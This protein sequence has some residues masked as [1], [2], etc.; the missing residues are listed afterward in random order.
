M[1]FLVP[2]KFDVTQTTPLKSANRSVGGP[3]SA[4]IGL[5]CSRYQFALHLR[6]MSS[7]ALSR[8]KGLFQF[9]Y[10]LWSNAFCFG[11]YPMVYKRFS[12][13]RSKFDENPGDCPF[14]LGLD[15]ISGYANERYIDDGL[16]LL[17]ICHSNT[18]LP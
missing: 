1:I 8:K 17:L 13:F 18:H 14:L 3:T 10:H 16:L 4:T 11:V 6:P 12:S 9:S 2:T 5:L 15:F 7:K